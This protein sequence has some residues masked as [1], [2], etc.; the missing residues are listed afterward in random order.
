MALTHS[1]TI[2]DL[3]VTVRELTVREVR[4]WA[5]K[6]SAGLVDID[7]VA[8][9]VLDAC[10]LHDIE[11]MSDKTVADFDGMAPSELAEIEG[12][13]RKLNPHF[14]RLRAAMAGA[15]QSFLAKA[16]QQASREPVPS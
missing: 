12:A 8:H 6:V 7:P 10:S 16:Q 5:A 4:D 14:F 9:L 13:C 11:L 3:T 15:A 1:L 2:N